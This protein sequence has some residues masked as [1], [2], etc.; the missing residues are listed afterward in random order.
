MPRQQSTDRSDRSGITRRRFTVVSG[1]LAAGAA[2]AFGGSGR[3]RA[4]DATPEGGD[5]GDTGGPPP[6]PEGVTVVAEGLFNPSN[7][8]FDADRTLYIAESGVAGGG[9]DPTGEPGYAT[10]NAQGTPP[11]GPPLLIPGQL[12]TITADG[13]RTVLAG[14]LG[15]VIGLVLTP[16]AIYVSAGGAS[17]GGG[18][19]P[20]PV[21]NTV[22]AIDPATGELAEV[23]A[24]G[25][26]EQDDNPDGTDVNPNL[27]GMAQWDDQL[28]VC[29]AGGNTVYRLDPA[30]GDFSVF[31][32]IP[33]LE[34]LTG[35]EP[36]PEM[37]PRQSVPTAV[38]VDAD[39]MIH[40]L[41][42]GIG[43]WPGPSLLTYT[44]DGELTPGAG[45]LVN[46]VAMTIGPDG[47]IYVTQLS[48]DFTGEMP[49]PG[50]VRRI[51]A[52]GS[53]EVVVEGLFFPHGL[54]FDVDGNLFI[55]VNS[56]I[57]GPEAPLGQV[58]RVDGVATP[59]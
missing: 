5:G 9:D 3:L 23:A 13:E 14:D 32:V 29:D 49:G 30:T 38:A 4:Q 56:I 2:F 46:A 59:A 42:L 17:V 19:L 41:L 39:G 20:D 16:E 10:P 28:L 34:E 24:L 55:T 44:P 21:E 6:L 8:A 31:T 15:G 7:L 1:G 35:G 53:N 47:L 50:S 18:F 33:T 58:V 37:G 26:Y 27:Y 25:V 40:V 45:G 11:A 54:T 52:D 12:T 57:S 51:L 36:D 22:D 48:D 43:F